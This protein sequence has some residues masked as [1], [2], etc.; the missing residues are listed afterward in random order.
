MTSTANGGIGFAGVLTIAFI[1]LKLA[2]FIAWSWLWVLAPLWIPTALVLLVL[3]VIVGVALVR[4]FAAMR[5]D[6]KRR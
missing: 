5:R 6:L 1:A 2:G 3:G 4:A